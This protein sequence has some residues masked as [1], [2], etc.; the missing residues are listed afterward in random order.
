MTDAELGAVL[1]CVKKRENK[2]GRVL[3]ATSLRESKA[4]VALPTRHGFVAIKADR[5]NDAKCADFVVFLAAAPK[6][7]VIAI[8]TKAGG[9]HAAHA[10]DQI[11]AALHLAG[12]DLTHCQAASQDVDH[13]PLWIHGGGVRGLQLKALRAAR[14]ALFGRKR[15]VAQRKAQPQAIVLTD[16]LR[17]EG[18][19]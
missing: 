12:Q 11:Q 16:V 18:L 2:R 15:P 14:P 3:E 10:A 5:N 4:S 17:Q 6:L 13:L 8:E 1:D 19:L 7:I 9:G